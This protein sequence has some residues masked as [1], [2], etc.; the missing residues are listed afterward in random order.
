MEISFF[1][2]CFWAFVCALQAIGASMSYD[3][4]GAIVITFLK[5]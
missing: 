1:A 5:L 4:G 2:V 3:G